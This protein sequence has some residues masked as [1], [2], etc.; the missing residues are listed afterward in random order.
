MTQDISTFDNDA[1]LERT[2]ANMVAD[3]RPIETPQFLD[4]WSFSEKHTYEFPGQENLGEEYKQWIIFESMNEGRKAEYQKRTNRDIRVQ[5][6]TKDIKMNMDPAADRHALLELSIVD[7]RLLRTVNGKVETVPFSKAALK[8]FLNV[9]DPSLI[10]KLEKAIRDK[11]EWM[12][13]ELSI[14]EIDAEIENLREQR[15]LAVKAQ[16]EK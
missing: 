16:L 12:R 3:G 6:T 13:A 2:H 11:N 5:N 8:N 9:A 14:E 4:L 10:Q 7:W 15:E 1:Q